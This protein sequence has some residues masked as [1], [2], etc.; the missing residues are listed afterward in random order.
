MLM[1]TTTLEEAAAGAG[2]TRTELSVLQ[3]QLRT[4]STAGSRLPHLHVAALGRDAHLDPVEFFA[5]DDLARQPARPAG[6]GG[7]VEHILLL[8]DRGGEPVE[9]FGGQDHVAGRAGHLPFAGA[10][11]RHPGSLRNLEQ[12]RACL[13]LGPDPLPVAC[14]ETDSNGC[15]PCCA[16][17]SLMNS[18]AASRSS[19]VV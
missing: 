6:A 3:P 10:F 2:R 1:Q 17:A 8:V 19:S 11:E 13:G 12:G 15:Y 7:E 5:E 4:R 14:N 16:A 18:A 9:P